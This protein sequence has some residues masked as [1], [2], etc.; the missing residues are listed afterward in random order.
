MLSCALGCMGA[1]TSQVRLCREQLQRFSPFGAYL[2][3][4]ELLKL[5]RTCSIVECG[6]AAPLADSPFYILVSGT[7]VVRE[8]SGS[9]LCYR[10]AGAF[11][12]RRVGLVGPRLSTAT[13]LLTCKGACRLLLVKSEEQYAMFV[14]QLSGASERGLKDICGSNTGTHLKHVPFI[15]EAGLTVEELRSVGEL[16]SYL[17]LPPGSN[18]FQQ[19]D[20]ATHFYI[21]LKGSVEVVV[22]EQALL[23]SGEENVQAGKRRAGDSIGVAAMIYKPCRHTGQS[24]IGQATSCR[25]NAVSST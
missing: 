1:E 6:D 12:S 23:G 16:C 22:N 10:Y 24:D 15:H 21:I 19:G 14:N 4:A 20:L 13:T 11:F 25:R 3:P 9:V 2:S 5:A 8:V 7:V 17:V 18:V